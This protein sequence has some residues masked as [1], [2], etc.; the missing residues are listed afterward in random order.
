MGRELIIIKFYNLPKFCYS[1]KIYNYKKERAI[2]N[3][4]IIDLFGLK[5]IQNRINVNP[6]HI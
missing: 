5:N 1:I 3:D 6:D 2:Y 4:H